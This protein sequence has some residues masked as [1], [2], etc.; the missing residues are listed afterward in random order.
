MR[1]I[2]EL[3]R[4]L[5]NLERMPNVMVIRGEPKDS[6]D[7]QRGVR[8]RKTNFVTPPEGRRWIMIDFDKI[9]LPTGMGVA[10]DAKAVAEY[11]VSL[12][13]PEFHDASYHY[14]LSSSAGLKDASVASMHVWFWLDQPWPDKEL[15]KWAKAVNADAGRKLIDPALFNDVQP[16]YVA[17]PVFEG[18][19][20]PFDTR[21]KLVC[22]ARKSVAISAINP[23]MHMAETTAPSVAGERAPGFEAILARIGDHPGGDGFH[24]PIIRAAA[25]Y[26]AA[27]G[28]EG[29]DSE[30]LYETLRKRVLEADRSQHDDD[31]YVEHMASREHIMAAIEG[32]LEKYGNASSRRRARVLEGAAA[33]Y[34]AVETESGDSARHRLDK[35]LR[36]VV[37]VFPW[38]SK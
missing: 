31:A 22:K 36:S 12:L 38:R 30:W 8:R 32:A 25:S 16:H 28:K 17:A 24:E 9:P 6:L 19:K 2:R 34:P 35:A 21:S 13:P 29:T 26:V 18:M 7:L 10:H 37:K 11:L 4:L 1:N 5:Q 23:Q 3:S 20:D 14:Q 15:K 27:N 33:H